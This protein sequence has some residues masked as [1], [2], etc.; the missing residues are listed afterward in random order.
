MKKF[1]KK[2]LTIEAI[3]YDG[4]N[5]DALLDIGGHEDVFVD[6]EH[7]KGNEDE[8]DEGALYVKKP[9]FPDVIIPIGG[10]LV[11]DTIGKFHVFQSDVFEATYEP[12]DPIATKDVLPKAVASNIKDGI[13]RVELENGAVI[14]QSV[15]DFVEMA[16]SHPHEWTT[17]RT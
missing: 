16:F 10:W 13:I 8:F 1:S 9:G 4:D 2:A 3:Q 5:I 6:L 15:Q 11:K 17:K 12:V 14:T 7:F